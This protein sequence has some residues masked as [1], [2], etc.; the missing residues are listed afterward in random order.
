M[1]AGEAVEKFSASELIQ[2]EPD[3]SSFPNGGS[4][5]TFEARGYT[6]WDISS[7]FFIVEGLNG[8][9]LCIPTAFIAYHGEALDI[10][11]PLLRANN[12]LSN[13]VVKFLNLIGKKDVNSVSVCVG[14]EQEY[15]LVDKA[16]YYARPDLVM[17]GKTLLGKGT[18]KSTTRRSLLWLHSTKSE[19]L[20]G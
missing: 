7:P 12:V 16:F 10:K 14:P 11:T 3:A 9:T 19:K 17:T 2:G 6:T 4:R 13:E 8:S 1:N 20:Y 5:S 18:S 15:F